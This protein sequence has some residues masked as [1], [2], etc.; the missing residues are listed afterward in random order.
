M[1]YVITKD[2]TTKKATT[3]TLNKRVRSVRTGRIVTIDQIV[4]TEDTE[5]GNAGNG[6]ILRDKYSL[7][8]IDIY[9]EA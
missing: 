5:L 9:V 7:Q 8:Q 1:R 6:Y 3:E 4:L 2:E